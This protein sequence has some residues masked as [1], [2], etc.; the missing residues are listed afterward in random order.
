MYTFV[1]ALS[2]Y[3]KNIIYFGE[4]ME[5]DPILG[6]YRFKRI[7]DY[8]GH[9]NNYISIVKFDPDLNIHKVELD[10]RPKQIYRYR[11][12]SRSENE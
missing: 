7:S 5:N 3:G 9:V 8:G 6:P 10:E 11:P 2:Q 4:E 12:F 1:S